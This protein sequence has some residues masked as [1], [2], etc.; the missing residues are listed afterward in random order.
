M[1]NYFLTFLFV[2]VLASCSNDKKVTITDDFAVGKPLAELKNKK[3]KEASGLV[4][5]I[6]NKGYF[7]T[8]NDSGNDPEVFLIDHKVS[9]K[10]TCKLKGVENRD[11]EDIAVGPGPEPGKSYIYVGDIG[12]NLGRYALKYIYRFEEPVL[13]AGETTLEISAVDRITFQLPD[14]QKDTETILINPNT[15]DLFV[16][17]KREDP[18]FVYQLKYPYSTDDTLTALKVCSLPLTQIVAGDFSADGKE[19]LLKN[20]EEVYYWSIPEG[21]TLTQAL[22]DAPQ[23]VTYTQ[24]PQGEAIT[25]ARDG[26]GFYTLSEKIKGEKSYLFFYKRK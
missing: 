1:R 8:I 4:E 22:K 6:G 18:V 11:W 10:L 21:R 19:L 24:E 17:S 20:Y 3:L 15:R 7:W 16:I 23:K 13:N 5:S 9:I 2:V 25:W 14:E 12:D 26:S